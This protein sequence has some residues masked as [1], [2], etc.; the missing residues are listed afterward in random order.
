MSDAA[1]GGKGSFWSSLPGV[2]AQIAAIILAL[3]TL[4]TVLADAGLLPNGRSTSTP[5]PVAIG[6]PVGDLSQLGPAAPGNAAND[7]RKVQ[8]LLRCTPADSGGDPTLQVNGVMSQATREAIMRFQHRQGIMGLTS[9]APD[10]R[11]DPG[12]LTLDRLNQQTG[13]G[14]PG[15]CL[16]QFLG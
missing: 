9:A 2:L 8:A 1:Q 12:G 5:T 14:Q 16:R 3:G 10:G 15:A 4:I 6:L 11:V 7:V 13:S